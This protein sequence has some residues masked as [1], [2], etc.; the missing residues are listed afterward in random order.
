MS[1]WNFLHPDYLFSALSTHLI[2]RSCFEASRSWVADGDGGDGGSAAG[3]WGVRAVGHGCAADVHS[4]QVPS[5]PSIP[6]H[7]IPSLHTPRLIAPLSW[8]FTSLEFDAPPQPTYP[9]TYIPPPCPYYPTPFHPISLSLP[10]PL[11]CWTLSKVQKLEYF[12]KAKMWYTQPQC[13]VEALIPTGAVYA[14]TM[15]DQG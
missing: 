15:A 2:L 8:S 5:C 6:T 7:P 9:P 1:V 12:I 13:A 11:R 4:M 3:A 10:L 14:A